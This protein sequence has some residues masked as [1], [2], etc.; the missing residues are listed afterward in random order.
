VS[1][2]LVGWLRA[3]L[4]AERSA[5]E[6]VIAG[7]VS[8]SYWDA[9]ERW[10]AYVNV[11]DSPASNDGL[12][13]FLLAEVAAKRAVLDNCRMAFA[14]EAARMKVRGA[15]VP[16]SAHWGLAMQVVQ[17]LAQPYRGRA[18]WRDEWGTA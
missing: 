11:V 2:E 9:G 18:G 1:V 14:Q 6:A 16:S 12:A 5:L 4:D 7:T 3:Q 10:D 17:G 15:A 13:R 8:E